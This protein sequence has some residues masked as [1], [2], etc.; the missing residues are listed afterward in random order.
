MLIAT[1]GACKRNGTPECC[2][3][4][5]AFIQTDDGDMYFKSMYE[6]QSTSQRGEINGL[7]LALA[8]A[9]ERALPDEPIIIITDSEYLFNTIELG[10][11]MKWEANQW[12]GATGPAKNS[13]MWAAVNEYLRRLNNPEPRVFM[14]W[15]KG[16]LFSYTP[17]N[18]RRAMAE[19][20]SGVELY[21]RLSAIANRPSEKDRII[22]DFNW[23]RAEH[24]KMRLPDDVA[25]QYVIAN[26]MA[27]SLAAF[28][29]HAMENVAL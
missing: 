21:S 12:M 8:E 13:D 28:V 4:G 22:R 16:H 9:N 15:T 2:S 29:V 6:T 11:S 1:D 20:N 27:D 25:L 19:D 7:L 23:N 26:M 17:A 18:V 14:Q 3:A 24:D 5:V 10:W